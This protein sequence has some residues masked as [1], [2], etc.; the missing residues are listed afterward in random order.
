MSYYVCDYY[1]DPTDTEGGLLGRVSSIRL[2]YNGDIYDIPITGVNLFPNYFGVASDVRAS[3]LAAGIPGDIGTFTFNIV[4]D[5]L[6]LTISGVNFNRHNGACN[7][8]AGNDSYGRISFSSGVT[9]NYLCN[10][11][12]ARTT[13]IAVAAE[14]EGS[15]V[16]C[17]MCHEITFDD[18][19]NQLLIETGLPTRQ[20]YLWLTNKFNHKWILPATSISNGVITLNNEIIDVY[21]LKFKYSGSWEVYFSTSNEINTKQ[22]FTRSNVQ[23]NCLILNFETQNE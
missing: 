15:I 12:D 20:Y 1:Y 9:S 8:F 7:S 23:Y 19:T 3:I 6:Y 18:C 5:F 4:D 22:L 17:E 11:V 10:T 2:T 13:C 21:G 14:H 16:R